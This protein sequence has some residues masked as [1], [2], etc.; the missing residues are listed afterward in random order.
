FLS[1][2]RGLGVGPHLSFS[3]L[4]S[5]IGDILPA[6]TRAR[7]AAFALFFVA[8]AQHYA[9]AD[10][11]IPDVV[12]APTNEQLGRWKKFEGSLVEAATYIGSGS[13]YVS[14]YRNPYV[15]LAL[16]AEPT[17]D[18]RTRYKL[19]LRA[20]LYVEEELTQ[21]DNPVGRRFYPYDPWFWLAADDLHTFERSK[22]KIG[23]IVRTVLPLSYESRYENMLFG[24]GAGPNVFR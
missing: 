7:A 6:V 11:A 8:W 10:T 14:G 3:R 18:L 9:L 5:T 12:K 21:P 24:I 20:R 17:Y 15:S 2:F 19:A 23:G 22:I 16:Y 1:G 13:F 4:A